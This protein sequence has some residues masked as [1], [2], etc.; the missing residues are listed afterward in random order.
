MKTDYQEA[1]VM[2]LIDRVLGL[3]K[4]GEFHPIDEIESK[5]GL[6]INKVKM[7][8]DFLADFSFVTLEDQ[9]VKITDGVKKWLKNSE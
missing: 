9:K 6:P 3:L 2:E 4:D 1:M 7:V 5:S 8:I